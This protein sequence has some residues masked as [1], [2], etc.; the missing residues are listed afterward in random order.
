[1]N[2]EEQPE[3]AAM[4][5][6]PEIQR[7]LRTI[8]AEFRETESDGLDEGEE[9]KAM[10]ILAES[11][12]LTPEDLLALPDSGKSYELVNGKLVEVN[13]SLLSSWVGGEMHGRLREFCRAQTAGRVWPP[14]SGIQCF[15]DDLTR[16]RK[17]D[18]YVVRRERLPEDWTDQ[19]YLRIPP[20]LVVEVISP[21]DLA[22][23][24]DEKVEEYLRAGVRLVWVV[25]PVARTVHIYRADGSIEGRRAHQELDG[26]DVLPGFHCPIRDLFPSPTTPAPNG[27]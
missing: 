13:V 6:D 2:T 20:D 11:T 8:E 27:Q 23:A 24:V 19:A 17:P 22:D 25:H 21:N 18:V 5:A 3:L 1:M 10:T 16:V 7:E 14:D 9:R 4:A 12:V 15:A 26:E